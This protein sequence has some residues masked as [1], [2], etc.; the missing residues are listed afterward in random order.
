MPHD[1][2]TTWECPGCGA[3]VPLPEDGVLGDL[4]GD[5]LDALAHALCGCYVL[6]MS[7][8]ALGRLLAAV[9]VTGEPDDPGGDPGGSPGDDPPPAG[10]TAGN[11]PP[12]PLCCR[13]LPIHGAIQRG[14]THRRC[15]GMVL[16]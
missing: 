4:A 2:T 7:D 3:H 6:D 1:C 9:L 10:S 16:G 5:R 11:D 13:R 14:L 8:N 15:V 12:H